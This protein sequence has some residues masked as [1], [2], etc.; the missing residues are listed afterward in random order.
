[1]VLE[2]TLWFDHG[3]VFISLCSTSAVTIAVASGI[4]EIQVFQHNITFRCQLQHFEGKAQ[5]WGGLLTGPVCTPN[6]GQLGS[7]IAESSS[8]QAEALFLPVVRIR[9]AISNCFLKEGSRVDSANERP[10]IAPIVE[11]GARVCTVRCH[12]LKDLTRRPGLTNWLFI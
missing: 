11:E 3:I 5:E 12:I 6:R 7:A 2:I 4:S 8:I 9:D 10:C 1:Q